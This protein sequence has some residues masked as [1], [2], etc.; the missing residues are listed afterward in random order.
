MSLGHTAQP[1]TCCARH[2]VERVE[3]ERGEPV[4]VPVSS[5]HLFLISSP[6]PESRRLP[7]VNTRLSTKEGSGWARGEW[8][9]SFLEVLDSLANLESAVE[10]ERVFESPEKPFTTTDLVPT[11]ALNSDVAMVPQNA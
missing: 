3:H 1:S 11:G 7:K 9:T 8:D 4:S 6:S 5:C 2:P 10:G